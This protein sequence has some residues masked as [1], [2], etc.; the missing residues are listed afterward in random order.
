MKFLST[1]LAVLVLGLPALS[2]HSAGDQNWSLQFSKPQSVQK[3]LPGTGM[4]IG[5]GKPLVRR[6]K[7]HDGKLWMSGA[8]APGVK[9]EDISKRQQVATARHIPIQRHRFI[10][11]FS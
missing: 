1:L 4:I 10:I 7:W 9:A 3:L 8:W 6:T 11:R 5:D 2:V